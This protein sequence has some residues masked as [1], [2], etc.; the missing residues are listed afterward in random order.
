MEIEDNSDENIWGLLGDFL[1]DIMAQQFSG[2]MVL[3]ILG[4][5]LFA[6]YAPAVFRLLTAYITRNKPGP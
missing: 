5:V 3:L 1:E 2:S 4:V 6:V